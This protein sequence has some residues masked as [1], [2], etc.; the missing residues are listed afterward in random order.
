MKKCS[1]FLL[2]LLLLFSLCACGQ[3]KADVYEVEHGGKVYT[4]DTVNCTVTVDGY[5]C[6][7]EIESGSSSTHFTVTYPDGSTYWWSRS[8]NGGMGGWSDDYDENRYVPG[9]VLRDVLNLDASAEWEQTGNPLLGI[10]L[11]AL[12]LFPAAAPR[13]AWTLSYG[14]RFKDAE[15]SE[16]ALG[17]NRVCGVATILLGIFCFFFG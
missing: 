8:G 4:V 10:L 14:W 7:Y 5:V 17:V 1:L 9:D 12:G 11:I 6:A 3:K 2:S 13:A 16:L 15:P